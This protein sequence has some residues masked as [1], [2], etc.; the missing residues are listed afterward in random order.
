MQELTRRQF[1][2]VAAATAV[3]AGHMITNSEDAEA[4][5]QPTSRPSAS[6][7]Y[8]AL[9]TTWC[10][11]MLA[12]QI[13]DS[14]DPKVHGALRCP[15]CGVLHGRCHDALYPMMH[16][17]HATGDSKYL[18]SAIRLQAWS[19]NVTLPT[20]EFTNDLDPAS[21][22]GITVFAMIALGDAIH[23]H[24]QLLDE[25]TR[26]RWRTRLARAAKFLDAWMT[27]ETGNINYPL[28]SSLAFTVAGDVLGERHYLDRGREFA[29]HS[30]EYFTKSGLLFGENH[31]A[32]VV[33]PK[34][35]RPVDLGYNVEETLPALALYAMRT[36]DQP[37]L[38]AVMKS[39][40]AHMEFM[41]PDGAWDNSWGTRM[42]KWTWWGSRTC[43]GCFPAY[44]LLADRDPRFAEVAW[45]NLA[46]MSSC[47]YEGLLYGGPHLRLNGDRPCVH[48][49]F[50]H[51]KSLAT[52]LDAG[53]PVNAKSNGALKLPRDES[54]GVKTFDEIR[55]SL[56]SIGPWRA[57]VTDCDVVYYK[58]ET[59]HPTGGALSLLYH[60]ALGPICVASMTEY[61][62][63]EAN[64]M[65][66]HGD[67]PTMPLTPRV[68]VNINGETYTS[69]S[70]NSATVDQQT[71]RGGTVF[72]GNGALL[73]AKRQPPATALNYRIS[74]RFTD[75][76]TIDATA[77]RAK[78]IVP[79]V[80]TSDEP[81]ER[82]SD[83]EVHIRK[84]ATTLVI[85]C[86]GGG[87]LAM[88]PQRVFNL[89]P[90]M[91]CLVFSVDLKPQAA[92]E[93]SVA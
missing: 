55:T 29:H 68:E 78:L 69:L 71:R 76:V 27:M 48:H 61:A 40:A 88:Q 21:W 89:V 92:I 79:I 83:A 39:L 73:S 2:S 60:A 59:G 84:P 19:D 1:L 56:I 82:K 16:L 51:A 36:N 12:Q 58:G 41:L 47:T 31:P 67:Y 32:T 35:C 53:G 28:T 65:Q 5:T 9:L 85:R 25:A 80:S 3:A 18:D 57:T 50:T 15:A 22:K 70:D 90:G 54:H 46:L 38:D 13:N 64:N 17:A 26:S 4:T 24:G 81:V 77:A 20:G 34:G 86:T 75:S 91:Q 62:L 45:R 33:T 87:T 10:D 11:G 66:K 52:V 74:Y 30:L 43:D 63:V 8:R 14:A 23:H 72:T 49:T 37:V 7:A 6:D 42:F 93:I 44:A